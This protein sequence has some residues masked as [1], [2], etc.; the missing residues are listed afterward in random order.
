MARFHHAEARKVVGPHLENFDALF[1]CVMSPWTQIRACDLFQAAVADHTS[2]VASKV[3]FLWA[4]KNSERDRIAQLQG[5]DDLA[6]L[7]ERLLKKPGIPRDTQ[8]PAG[9]MKEDTGNI[10]TS[11]RSSMYLPWLKGSAC[12]HVAR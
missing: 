5:R 11:A 6:M 9:A 3:G 12:P 4:S 8:A 7:S 10:P 1:Q 2:S